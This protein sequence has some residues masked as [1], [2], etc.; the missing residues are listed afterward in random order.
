MALA[1]ASFTGDRAPFFGQSCLGLSLSIV[2][3]VVLRHLASD[4]REKR[5]LAPAEASN[6]AD[7]LAALVG[8][9]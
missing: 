8:E 5:M 6:S 1:T 7:P 2:A 9:G 3:I 4:L